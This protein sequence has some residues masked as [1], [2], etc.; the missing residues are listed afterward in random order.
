MPPQAREAQDHSMI[1]RE[2][3]AGSWKRDVRRLLVHGRDAEAATLAVRQLRERD[4]SGPTEHPTQGGTMGPIEQLDEIGPLIMQLVDNIEA[5]QLDDS[6][7]CAAFTVRGVLEH[8]IGGA[9]AFAAAFRGV[10]P[11]DAPTNGNGGDP[12]QQIGVALGGLVE[13]MRSPGALDRTI[14]APFGEVPGSD[15]AR[16]VA[17]DGLVHGWDLATATGQSYAPNDA[18]VAEVDAFARAAISS[19][20]RHGD[21]FG[22]PTEPPKGASPIERLAAFTGRRI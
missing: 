6:T 14:A 12:R 18:L 17:L 1:G 8:M 11:A 7:P 4:R 20:M 22:A 3:E 13:S 9:T 5:D 21:V 15:F 2:P 16:F 10:A 19:D